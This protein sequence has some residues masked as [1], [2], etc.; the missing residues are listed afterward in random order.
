MNKTIDF[1]TK[2]K[3]RA[4]KIKFKTKCKLNLNPIVIQFK[5]Y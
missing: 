4:N 3:I 2:F 1:F 5:N